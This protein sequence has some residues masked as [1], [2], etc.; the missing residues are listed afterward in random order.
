MLRDKPFVI[1]ETYHLYNRGAHKQDIFTCEADYRRLSLLLFLANNSS[2]VNIRETLRKYKGQTFAKI[3]EEERPDKSL[4]DIYAYCLMPNH[5]H[6]ILHGKCEG[7]VT[8]FMTKVLTGYSMYFN[9]VHGHSGILAQGAFKSKHIDTEAYFRYI[10]SYV[11]INPVSLV[12]P[13]W[14]AD[15]IADLSVV[16]DFFQTYQYSSFYDYS[17]GLRP[18][19]AV[20]AYEEAPDFLKTQNDL[21]ELLKLYNTCKG[22]TFVRWG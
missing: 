17:I 13:N 14:E 6:L 4:V 8:K 16:R 3:F 15:G 7:G 22:Q 2:P 20:L 19:R 9:T 10:F 11:H 12:A 21:E 18:E 1:G 5:F